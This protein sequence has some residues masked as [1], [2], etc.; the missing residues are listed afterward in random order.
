MKLNIN[1]KTEKDI[2]KSIRRKQF[3]GK[4]LTKSEKI[5]YKYSEL[6]WFLSELKIKDYKEHITDEQF[7]YDIRNY[8]DKLEQ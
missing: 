4:H 2:I 3:K 6:R 7:I 8:I 5:I 1:K